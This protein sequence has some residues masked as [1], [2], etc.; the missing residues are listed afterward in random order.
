[1][2][3]RSSDITDIIA[4]MKNGLEGYASDELQA[5]REAA[6][7][8]VDKARQAEERKLNDTAARYGLRGAAASARMS[9]LGRQNIEDTAQMEQ[10][11][12][13][14]NADERNRRL[15]DYGSFMRG[16]EDDEFSRV[17]RAREAQYGMASD[18]DNQYYQRGREAIGDYTTWLEKMRAGDLDV[19]KANADQQMAQKDGKASDLGAANL[20]NTQ[21]QLNYAKQMSGAGGFSRSRSRT[22]GTTSSATDPRQ[23]WYDEASRLAK[24]RAK[25]QGVEV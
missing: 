2:G 15:G 23:A 3:K 10:D 17:Q 1:V 20:I 18:V 5:F 11:L 7:R 24:E 21:Q 6:R 22:S 14:K 19:Q 16:V 8:E 13:I 4:R 9:Q 25:N 12:F